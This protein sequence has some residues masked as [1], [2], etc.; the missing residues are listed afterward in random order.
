MLRFNDVFKRQYK[1]FHK[2]IFF[3]FPLQWKSMKIQVVSFLSYNS[4]L[5]DNVIFV[6]LADSLLKD[7]V[8]FV[9]LAKGV[10]E[11]NGTPLQY[12]CLENPMDA[13]AW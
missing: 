10:G 1:S 2:T 7:T 5:K 4:L 6:S 11:G 9:S 8:I 3:H 12:S 13:G